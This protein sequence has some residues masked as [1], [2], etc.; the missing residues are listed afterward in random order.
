[1]SINFSVEKVNCEDFD[2]INKSLTKVTRQFEEKI[3][4]SE[5]KYINKSSE[6]KISLTKRELE[7]LRFLAEGK[8]NAEISDSLFVSL[9]T[10]KAHVSSIINKL[11][12]N[13]RTEASFIAKQKGLI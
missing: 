3:K 5:P 9:S 1:M 10:A 7:V 12:A 2:E 4:Y 6:D 13:D 8:N 11:G